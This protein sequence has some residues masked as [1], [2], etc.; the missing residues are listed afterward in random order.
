MSDHSRAW[1]RLD[2]SSWAGAWLILHPGE[3]RALGNTAHKQVGSHASHAC[4]AASSVAWNDGVANCSMPA[5][6]VTAAQWRSH[7]PRCDAANL[8]PGSR[9]W[10]RRPTTGHARSWWRVWVRMVQVGRPSRRSGTSIVWPRGIRLVPTRG[11][12]HHRSATQRPPQLVEC[13]CRHTA[14][15]GRGGPHTPQ[16]SAFGSLV[17]WMHFCSAF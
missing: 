10:Q 14:G 9:E 3:Q 17:R 6:C 7:S 1:P 11:R 15:G 16:G 8:H 2:E 5:R 13:R 12:P 4:A